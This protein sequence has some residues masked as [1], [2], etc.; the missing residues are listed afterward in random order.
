M[1][2]TVNATNDGLTIDVI[3]EGSGPPGKTPVKGVDYWTD[4][5]KREI[6][7]EVLEEIPGGGGG[8]GKVF[9]VD[10][11]DDQT[12]LEA[13]ATVASAPQRGD[14]GIVRR[15]IVD[16]KKSY[17]AYVYTT[18]WEAMDGNYSAD[19][20]IYPADLTITS[21]LGVHS[22][23]SSGSKTLPVSGMSMRAMMSYIAA[24]EKNP[25]IT[26]PSVSI[27]SG[28]MGAKEVGTRISP[29]Y[30]ATLNP[31]SY[32][33]GPATGVTATAWTVKDTGNNT[34]TTASG[35]FPEIQVIEST[36]YS[37][38][39]TAQHA[40]GAVP[41]TNIG[42]PYEAGRIQAGSK[43]AS[44]GTITGYRNSFYGTRTDKTAPL[45]SAAIR[46]LTM[47][48]KALSNGATFN[49]SIPVG[50]TRVIICYPSTLRDLTSVLD[51]NGL[52][53]EIKSGFKQQSIEVEGANGYTA[54]SYKCYT[55]EYAN[56]NDTVNTYKV[57]I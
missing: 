21:T 24:E 9:T 26:Q 17:T 48:N 10:A 34:L 56:P 42:N 57:T 50:A 23:D 55:L 15:G 43:S 46:A 13:L 2:I 33:Y 52:N 44:R 47:S 28:S 20:V 22:P 32:Q 5:D 12:D 49:V 45:D 27:T 35:T 31:G 38:T 4:E 53:A 16:D 19:N 25:S 36:S 30:S 6:I 39:A 8:L 54:T 1:E 41:V 3:I 7:D 18:Q 40:Q 14:I 29:Q 11:E 37:I 51:V